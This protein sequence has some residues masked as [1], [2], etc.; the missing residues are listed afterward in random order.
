MVLRSYFGGAVEVFRI[1][2]V[3]WQDGGLAFDTI[4]APV[5]QR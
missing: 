3:R 2:N 1:E 4:I 5:A